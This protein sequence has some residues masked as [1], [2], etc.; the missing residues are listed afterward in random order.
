MNKKSKFQ[1][2]EKGLHELSNEVNKNLEQSAVEIE[3]PKCKTLFQFNEE[4]NICPNCGV[5]FVLE[6][7]ET[8]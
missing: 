3:C 1:L 5:N 7:H 8:Q 6:T 4:N 2:N